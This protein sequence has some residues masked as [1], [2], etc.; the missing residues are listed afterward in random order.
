MLVPSFSGMLRV[1]AGRPLVNHLLKGV[2]LVKGSI[3]NSFV[4]VIVTYVRYLH[5]LNNKNG[6]SYVAKY[7]KCCVSLLMQALAGAQHHSTQELGVGI[8]RTNRGLPRIIPKLHRMKIREGN[9]LYIRLWLTLFSF[10]RVIDFTGR[11]KISTI[12][13]PSKARINKDEIVKATLSIKDQFRSNLIADLSKEVLKP[14]WIASSSPNTLNVRVAT[15][16]VSSYSTSIYAVIGSLRAYAQ[17][18][19]FSTYFKLA[20][21]SSFLKGKAPGLMHPLVRVIQHCQE[22]VKC[23]PDS[24]L[25]RIREDFNFY[26]NYLS[27]EA[28]LKSSFLGK[29]S[30]KVE[31]AGKIRVFAMVDCFTQWLLAPL[32]KG[33]FNFLR[34]IPEDATHDQNLTLSTFVGRLKDNGIKD[35]Y[36]FDLTAATD[37]IPVSAQALILD[38][39]LERTFGSDW[40]TFLTSRWYQLSTPSWDP[41]AISCV[42]L[43]I[44]PEKEKDNPY[45]SLKLSKPGK[46]GQRIPYVDAVK[47]ATGQPMGALSSWA[48]LALTHHIMVR[49]AALRVGY[50]EFSLYLVLGD[51]LVIA[52]KRVAA[53]YLD[54]AK[55]WDIEINLSK[56][57]ISD[58]GSLEFAKRFIFKYQDVSGLSFREMAVSKYDIRGLLQLFTRIGKI[59]NTRISELLSFLGHGYRALSR[60]N[61]RFEKLGTGMRRSLLLLSYPGMPFSKLKL[62]KDWLCSPSFNKPGKRAILPEQLEYLKDLGRKTADSVKQSYLPRNPSEFKSFFFSM[63][64]PHNRFDTSYQDVFTSPAFEKAWIEVGEPLQAVLLPMYEEIHSTWDQTVVTVKDTYDFDKSLDLETLWTQLLDLDEISSE[65]LTSSE[66]RPINDI[67]TLGSSLLLKRADVV[68]SH[69]ATLYKEHKPQVNQPVVRYPQIAAKGNLR[70]LLAKKLAAMKLKGK[71][72]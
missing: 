2:L 24:V 64:T 52:D 15:R 56:S 33:I 50:R 32:H 26:S 71:L 47:Y 68:R 4:K 41:K 65:S 13:T 22:A 54:I 17:T 11:L 14:F 60:I 5:Y 40:A 23:I 35:V 59:R 30:F 63:L 16:N 3:T 57:I 37:R 20:I 27:D 70:D 42:S 39:M 1:K 6:P 21:R 62:Y 45:L 28:Y 31:P 38:T 25:Y 36:S 34:K 55:E 19:M 43:G 51:D 8:S 53:S 49:M 46:D 29:L 10:Y 12:I 72:G 48:M 67:I 69:F 18:K 66:F 9:T 44:D 58:N 61:T 7:L